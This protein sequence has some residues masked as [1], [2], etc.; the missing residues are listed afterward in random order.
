MF[1]VGV[2][3]VPSVRITNANILQCNT[4]LSSCNGT[5]RDLNIGSLS[6][7]G[8]N[9]GVTRLKLIRVLCCFVSKV[10][11]ISE[12]KLRVEEYNVE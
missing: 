9:I 11:N 5:I 2:N 6:W 1:I 12:K 3:F 4:C 8:P 7:A 10:P